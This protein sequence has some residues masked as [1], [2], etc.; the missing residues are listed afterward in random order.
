MLKT[1]NSQQATNLR[2]GFCSNPKLL[3]SSGQSKILADATKYPSEIRIADA[4]AVTATQNYC[5]QFALLLKAL[6]L[7][8][9]Y[10]NVPDRY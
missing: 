5:L 10:C 3:A 6:D 8:L 9:G 7:K 2:I 4:R 1:I